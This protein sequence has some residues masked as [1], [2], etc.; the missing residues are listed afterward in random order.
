MFNGKLQLK[1]NRQYYYQVQQQLMITGRPYCDFIVC[2]FSDTGPLFFVER[3]MPDPALWEVVVPKLTQ[4]WGTC[5]LPELISRW[6]TRKQH[7][8]IVAWAPDSTGI[9]YC[10]KASNEQ[11]LECSNKECAIKKF[12][13]S[14]LRLTNPIPKTWYCPSC[15]LL[16]QY[17]KFRKSAKVCDS[18]KNEEAMKLTSMCLQKSTMQNR[19]DSKV[20][21]Q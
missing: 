15:L 20:Q 2:C 1:R 10:R 14:C 4:T 3:I 6:Y 12:H 17:K 5:V 9:C 21:Q 13:Y 7:I 18:L 19:Q 8:P 16:P 11:T